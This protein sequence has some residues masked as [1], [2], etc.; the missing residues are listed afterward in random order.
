MKCVII[1]I[2]C[3]IG[4][5]VWSVQTQNRAVT[6]VKSI[7][8]GRLCISDQMEHYL[9]S[10]IAMI[11]GIALIV[12]VWNALFFGMRYK[13]KIC[14]TIV[15]ISLMTGMF[16]TPLNYSLELDDAT[17][18]VEAVCGM[19]DYWNGFYHSILYQACNIVFYHPITIAVLQTALFWG[20]DCIFIISYS[21]N[22]TIKMEWG[23]MA[24]FVFF[25]YI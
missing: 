7:R 15:L 4:V 11:M 20:G 14:L 12:L 24:C 16:V 1:A 25:Q 9:T 19:A 22:T 2:H 3:S 13:R 6:R 21:E 23:Y 10:F 8:G 17:L 18:Y 5:V